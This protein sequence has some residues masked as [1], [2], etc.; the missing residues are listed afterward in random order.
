MTKPLESDRPVPSQ[1]RVLAAGCRSK[2]RGSRLRTAKKISRREMLL[3]NVDPYGADQ[4]GHALRRDAH[5]GIG[6][7]GGG[8][9]FVERLE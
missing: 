6:G 4:I 1:T 9:D 8:N 7:A 2:P 3:A 5:R